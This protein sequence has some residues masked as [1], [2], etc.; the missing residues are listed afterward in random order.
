MP[1]SPNPNPKSHFSLALLWR[2]FFAVSAP[3]EATS[4]LRGARLDLIPPPRPRYPPSLFTTRATLFPPLFT[5]LLTR[6]LHN[7]A[8]RPL[9]TPAHSPS[10]AVVAE[11]ASEFI[12][13]GLAEAIDIDAWLGQPPEHGGEVSTSGSELTYLTHPPIYLTYLLTYLL[14]YSRSAAA[15]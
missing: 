4:L 10:Q 2:T 8:H 6:P 9:H 1:R 13:I 14:T 15:R 11:W 5:P 3:Q 7:P 12:H